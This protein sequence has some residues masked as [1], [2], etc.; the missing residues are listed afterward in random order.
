M[1]K[2]IVLIL[3][4]IRSLYNIGAIFRTAEAVG[5]D[6]VYLTGYSGVKKI[7]GEY[8]LNEKLKKTAL[9]GIHL[10]WEYCNN[11]IDVINKLKKQKYQIV[12]L[13]QTDKSKQFNKIKYKYPVCLI[14]GNEVYGLHKTIFD[15]SDLIV[16]I[17]MFGKG[18]SLNVAI[19]ISVLLYH[20]K[21]S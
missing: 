19:A 10:Q 15:K 16:D 13:E 6:V 11:P 12:S 3:H 18:K 2:S 14:A 20:V 5:V 7:A 9:E 4:N 1:E 8:Y 17:P 21:L